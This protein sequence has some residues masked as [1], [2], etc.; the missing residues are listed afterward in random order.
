MSKVTF[1]VPTKEHAALLLELA[2]KAAVNGPN[3]QRLA[4]LYA[5][6]QECAACFENHNGK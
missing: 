1:S 6:A 2:E 3:A 4:D 5:A